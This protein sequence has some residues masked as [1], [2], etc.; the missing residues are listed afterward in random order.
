MGMNLF[1]HAIRLVLN[2]LQAALRISAL[3][4]FVPAIVAYALLSGADPSTPPSPL[5]ILVSI[6]AF[7]GSLAIAVAWHRFIL[8]DEQPAGWLPAFDGRRLLSYFGYSLL[9]GVIAL[10]IMIA[11]GLVLGIF[12][13]LG[14]VILFVLTSFVTVFVVLV[15]GFRLALILPASS[16]DKRL[17]LGE[18][19]SA[20]SGAT[21]DIVVLA[22]LCAGAS[23][24]LGLVSL[25]FVGPLSPLGIL[26]DA[27]AGWFSLMVGLSILTTLYG[28]YFEGRPISG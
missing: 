18:A 8:L 21:G 25:I 27:A 12:A 1:V 20:T 13:M 11:V 6:I 24:V 19:W 2:N 26:W 17:G 7:I 10:V 15:I 9:L 23:V 3:L 14:G 28:H 4:Y 5:A 22:L 16:V